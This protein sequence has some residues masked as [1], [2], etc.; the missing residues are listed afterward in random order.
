MIPIT[1]PL[2]NPASGPFGSGQV[3]F[4]TS[5][6]TWTVPPGVG[7]LR[8]RVWGGGGA[9]HTSYNVGGAGGGFAMKTIYD[10]TGITTV[11]ITVGLGGVSGTTAGINGSGYTGGTSSFGSYVSA[12]GGTAGLSNSTAGAGGTGIGGDINYTGG[13]SGYASISTNGG[14]GGSASFFG[15]G[16][17]GANSTQ[18]G[19][20]NATGGAGG[21]A[22]QGNVNS[23]GGNGFLGAGGTYYS[24]T[25]PYGPAKTGMENLFSIDFIGTGGGGAGGA[26]GANGGG[27]GGGGSNGCTFG[28]FPGGG[29]GNLG[30]TTGIRGG[31]NGL[32]IV[33]W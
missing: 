25:V 32:V 18:Q 26:P 24:T 29:S 13:A 8:V 14:G 28:G 30:N 6:T 4:F 10:M 16:A 5:S 33:E 7:K 22:Y 1:A 23:L 12:T 3:Q 31:G 20:P 11:A 9:Q 27:G 19:S 17:P 15:N 2:N 21:G